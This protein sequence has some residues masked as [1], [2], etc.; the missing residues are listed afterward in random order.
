ML[1][2][3]L[4]RQKLTNLKKVSPTEWSG[5]CPFHKEDTPSFHVNEI[6][7]QYYCFGCG[8]SGNHHTFIKE[9]GIQVDEKEIVRDE[10]IKSTISGLTDSISP[11][12]ISQLHRNLLLDSKR[13]E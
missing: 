2:I 5:L 7:G 6:T 1:V 4:Y 9:F 13:I 12:V 11:I 10:I 8:K 3:E